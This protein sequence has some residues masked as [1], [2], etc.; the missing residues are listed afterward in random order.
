[1]EEIPH[2]KGSTDAAAPAGE[3]YEKQLSQICDLLFSTHPEFSD[4]GTSAV[5]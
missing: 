2:A 1:M 3:D 5:S 4:A